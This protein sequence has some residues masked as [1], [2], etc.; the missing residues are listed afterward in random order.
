MAKLFEVAWEKGGHIRVH[1]AS[2]S[3]AI[4]IALK[5][6]KQTGKLNV[7]PLGEPSAAD[8]DRMAEE[9][10]IR[11]RTSASIPRSETEE[12]GRG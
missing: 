6:L 4:E 12:D 1:A 8:L 10:Q 2:E 5:Y 11:E 9:A 3:E 7:R